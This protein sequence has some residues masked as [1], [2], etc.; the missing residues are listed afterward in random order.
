MTDRF[1][2]VWHRIRSGEDPLAFGAVVV[3][4]ALCAGGLW[5]WAGAH[6]GG[7]PAA[8][9]S[10]APAGETTDRP[11]AGTGRPGGGAGRSGDGAGRPGG[12]AAR[13]GD[14]GGI[15]PPIAF[16]AGATGTGTGAVSTPTGPALAVHVAGAVAHP[17][18][19]HLEAGSR[20]ADAVARAGGGLARADLDRLNLAARLVDGQKVYVARRGEPGPPAAGIAIGDGS[21]GEGSGPEPTEPVDL[22]AAG[23][24]ALDSLPGIGPATARAIL[25]E[26]ARRGGFRSTRDLLRVAGIGEGRFARLKDRVRV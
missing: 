22:N 25:E 6:H 2:V 15:P 13:S 1:A 10:P 12:P 14:G 9:A 19:Y 11:E 18:L 17:G 20:V 23:L 3:V 24:A 16:G 21:A 8:A 5:F 4:L 26:R 7:V